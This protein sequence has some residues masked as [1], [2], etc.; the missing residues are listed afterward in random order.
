MAFQVVSAR[1]VEAATELADVMTRAIVISGL[2][3]SSTSILVSASAFQGT[4]S[5]LVQSRFPLHGPY[6]VQVGKD[7]VVVMRVRLPLLF[8]CCCCAALANREPCQAEAIKS[9][10]RPNGLIYSSSSKRQQDT[11]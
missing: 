10:A 4:N 9:P 11:L 5:T 1:V 3:G 7:T 6:K 8:K 2:E